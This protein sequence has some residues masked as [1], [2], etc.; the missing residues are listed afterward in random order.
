MRAVI[1]LLIATVIWGVWGF[2]N[3]MAV[4][5]AH[6]FTVQWIYSIPYIL[7]IPVWFWL[8]SREAPETNT[9][10]DAVVWAII[11]AVATMLAFVIYLFAQ[12]EVSAS[13]A[14]A[15]LAAYP[16]VTLILSVLWR[17]ESITIEKLLGIGL[18]IAGVIVLSFRGS[19]S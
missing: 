2:A 18:I 15:I 1:L 16:I 14:S 7:L 19:S 6:P 9:N 3:K 11:S 8:G 17:L 13:V 10:N 12:R 5:R 4:D